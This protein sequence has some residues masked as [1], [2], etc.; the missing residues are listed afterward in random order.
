MGVD[1]TITK[2]GDGSSFPKKG[3]TLIVHYTGKLTNG[4]VFDSSRTKGRPF[5]FVYGTGSVIKGWEVGFGQLSKG[6]QATLKISPDMAYGK[7]GAGGVIPPDATLIF[8]V[9]LIDIQKK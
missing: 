4:K 3:D 7:A 2:E 1:T 6:A 5:T 8:D 9:E